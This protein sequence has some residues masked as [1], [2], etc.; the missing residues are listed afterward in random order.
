[1]ADAWAA[2]TQVDQRDV[3]QP[4]RAMEDEATV[5]LPARTPCVVM[6][7]FLRILFDW[8]CGNLVMTFRVY[9][10]CFLYCN[11]TL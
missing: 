8:I 6:H 9:I 5:A 10:P 2:G 1:M 7:R 11:A 3:E 4:G